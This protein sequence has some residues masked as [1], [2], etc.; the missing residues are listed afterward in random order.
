[1]EADNTGKA[2]Y[3][4]W[5]MV[6]VWSA[7]EAA[8]LLLGYEPWYA[9][10][11]YSDP[12]F[13]GDNDEPEDV[14]RTAIGVEARRLEKILESAQL[15]DELGKVRLNRAGKPWGKTVTWQKW[16]SW[17]KS[18]K[19]ECAEELLAAVS[20]L[21]E[22]KDTDEEVLTGIGNDLLGVWRIVAV[23]ETSYIR[24]CDQCFIPQVRTVVLC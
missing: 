15:A 3:S 5:L 6:R 8:A 23:R 13:G 21:D 9:H 11:F 10:Y 12:P 4:Y 19:I 14:N 1:M 20:E 24:C 22:Q 17:A 7:H 2:D 18:N 16:V